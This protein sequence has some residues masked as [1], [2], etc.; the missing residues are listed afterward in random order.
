M[1]VNVEVLFVNQ[2][3][4]MTFQNVG[5]QFSIGKASAHQILQEQIGM[6]KVSTG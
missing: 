1:V 4:R 6:S 2:G 5:N 3:S